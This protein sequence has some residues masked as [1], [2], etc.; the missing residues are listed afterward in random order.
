M[1]LTEQQLEIIIRQ[2]VEKIQ[3]HITE[4]RVKF[5]DDLIKYKNTPKF[6]EIE[7]RMA[8]MPDPEATRTWNTLKAKA[9]N[10]DTSEAL[11]S[12]LTRFV[13]L[14]ST[15]SGCRT[16]T[17]L[18]RSLLSD[19]TTAIESDDWNALDKNS[20]PNLLAHR[21]KYPSTSHESEIDTLVWELSDHSRPAE[22]KRY[23]NEFPSGLHRNECDAILEAQELWKGVSTDP[24]LITLSDYIQEEPGSPFI[25]DALNLIDDLK[26]QEIEKMKENPGKYELN[27]LSMLLENGIFNCDELIGAGVC[28]PRTMEFINKPPELPDIEQEGN[29]SPIIHHGSTD[30]FLFGIPSSGKTC[31][32]MG[33]LGAD[34]FSYDNA[35]EGKGGEYADNLK[36]Y[37]DHGKAP[38]R[39]YGN[40]VTQ[41]PGNIYPSAEQDITYPVNLIEM[42]GEE[43]AMKIAYNPDNAIDFEDMGT[44]A[45]RLLTSDNKKVIFIVI[46]P[47]ADGLIKI[48]TERD[49]GSS[50]TK[51]VKQEIVISRIVNMLAKNPSVLK[52]TNAIHFI[53]TKADT[54]GSREDR[55][56]I[57]VE[58]IRNLYRHTIHN[59]K[60]LCREYG[61]NQ[62][63]DNVPL[64]YTFSLGNFYVGD[65]FE[66]DVKDANKI[67]ES[68]KSMC[69]GEKRKTFFS[70]LKKAVNGT[71]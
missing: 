31:V 12:E 13:N 17:D 2:S 45:T 25:N 20:V 47:T 7:R 10:G 69:Q 16:I 49:D 44:G 19:L 39:T 61:I 48:S 70:K 35:S 3:L 68:L 43:F 27:N 9:D 14:Y 53:M 56:L 1:P 33:L 15:K 37:R 58:R 28:T 29:P 24:D 22:I 42:S 60:S 46:D 55:E 67:M 59:L 52:R 71:I 41:I 4:G 57:A 54:I 11:I 64:L 62:T 5:P 18:A 30:V 65:L 34:E 6:K 63:S 38:G 32:L 23:L 36:L 40:F 26:F 66:Y 8:N 51:I 21:R 50:A